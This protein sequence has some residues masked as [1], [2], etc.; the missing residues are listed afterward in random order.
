M[1]DGL[2]G[3][4]C[5]GPF[6]MGLPAVLFLR[7]E[8]INMS[9]IAR[10]MRRARRALPVSC[11]PHPHPHA[12]RKTCSRYVIADV[13][14]AVWGPS[15]VTVALTGGST[16]IYEPAK[17]AAK[18]YTGR[19]LFTEELRKSHERQMQR[20]T[21][22]E[23]QLH[24]NPELGQLVVP[25]LAQRCM[26]KKNLDILELGPAYTTAVPEAMWKLLGTYTAVDFS[27][28][29]LLK[30]QSF[31]RALPG[32]SARYRMITSDTY[33]LTLASSSCDLVVTSCHPPLVSAS[34]EDK[35]M[36]IDKVHSLLREGGTFV[37]FPW[38][39]GEQ[40]C[41]V[42][43]HLLE[44]FELIQVAHQTCDK[45]RLLLVLEKR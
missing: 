31:L 21:L 38:Y 40:Q 25:V 37:V 36:V 28:P 29:Y 8:D 19:L 32:W 27:K 2:N 13:A 41:Q 20:L 16:Q 11:H 33:E 3:L 24:E 22:F 30:Q 9:F 45:Q 35:C 18:P 42:N 5:S 4:S 15:G 12:P 23:K 26:G 10:L 7:E 44:R 34:V 39:F 6:R 43:Q 14:S 1:S 17:S